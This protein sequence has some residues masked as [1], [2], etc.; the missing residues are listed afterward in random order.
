MGEDA[1]VLGADADFQDA[2]D[3]LRLPQNSPVQFVV[4]VR[5]CLVASVPVEELAELRGGSLG[6][7][8]LAETSDGIDFPTLFG[9][10]MRSD[11]TQQVGQPVGAGERML[12]AGFGI[13]PDRR[14][15]GLKHSDDLARQW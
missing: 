5:A 3:Q 6:Q 13:A 11:L 8:I 12:N 14:S 4:V 9:A 7:L 15:V 10:S 2:F 1:L